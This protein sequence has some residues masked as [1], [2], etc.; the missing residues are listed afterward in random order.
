MSTRLP[1]LLIHSGASSRELAARLPRLGF[2]PVE[3]DS[4]DEAIAAL[5]A[6]GRVVSVGLLPVQLANDDLKGQLKSLRRSGPLEHV[7]LIV[8]G[9]APD[10]ATRKLL[11]RAD[12]DLALW[13]PYDDGGLR[14]QLHRALSGRDEDE[15]QREQRRVPT[16]L[17]ARVRAGDRIRDAVVY[18]L[19]VT[20][21]FLETPRASMEGAL[22]SVELRLPE[23]VIDVRVEV[24]YSNVPGNLSRPNL[25]FGM[26]VRF[27]SLSSEH[28]KL[29][30]GYVDERW[31]QL[32]V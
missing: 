2:E 21:A 15:D 3:V 9:R 25:P 29:I 20:G 4:F 14:F 16:Y 11:R 18:S 1:V 24:I 12:L 32:H 23:A 6:P 10:A 28:L 7:E 8:Y 13:E 19:S 22:L 26:G 27:A 5:N 30:E 31:T 17:M